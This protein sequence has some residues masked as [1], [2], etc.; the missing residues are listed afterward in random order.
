MEV[1]YYS[2]KAC[3]TFAERINSFAAKVKGVN[4][5]SMVIPKQCAYYIKDS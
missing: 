4:V 3:L 1:F 5:Y 2:E